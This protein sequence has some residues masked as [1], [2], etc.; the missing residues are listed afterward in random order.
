MIIKK[1]RLRGSLS[2]D[3]EREGFEPFRVVRSSPIIYEG[4]KI[5]TPRLTQVVFE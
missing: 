1:P 3:A 2:F 5:Q 4:S